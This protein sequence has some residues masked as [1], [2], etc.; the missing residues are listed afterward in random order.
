LEPPIVAGAPS[1]IGYTTEVPGI[2]TINNFVIDLY[3]I[4]Q[5]GFR[6]AKI[7]I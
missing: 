2:I 5:E 1:I 3:E 4:Q 7:V 6:D